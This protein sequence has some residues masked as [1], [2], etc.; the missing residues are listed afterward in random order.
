MIWIFWI[1]AVHSE[2]TETGFGA[3]LL[4][5]QEEIRDLRATFELGIESMKWAI[6]ESMRNMVRQDWHVLPPL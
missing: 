1:N 5:I 4:T 6:S 2:E 3:L